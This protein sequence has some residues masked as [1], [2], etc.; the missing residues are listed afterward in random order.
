[1]VTGDFQ[2]KLKSARKKKSECMLARKRSFG[3]KGMM[4][5]SAVSTGPARQVVLEGYI[6]LASDAWVEST[7]TSF[8]NHPQYPR[9]T[10][11]KN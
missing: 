11:K 3:N 4:F 1:M 6:P 7:N 8:V 2:T 5:S 10:S 9:G